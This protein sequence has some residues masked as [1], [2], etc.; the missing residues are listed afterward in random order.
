MR[1]IDI[2]VDLLSKTRYRKL[3]KERSINTP[4]DPG[5]GQPSRTGS[6]RHPPRG[7]N[8]QDNHRKFLLPTLVLRKILFFTKE[9]CLSACGTSATPQYWWLSR[10]S[11]CVFVATLLCITNHLLTGCSW[12]CCHGRNH[13]KRQQ[14]RY[15]SSKPDSCTYCSCIELNSTDQLARLCGRL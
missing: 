15:S 14:G 10:K 6:S 2:Q 1:I 5:T 7:G 12:G 4:H 9:T 13:V 3:D 8:L 11:E